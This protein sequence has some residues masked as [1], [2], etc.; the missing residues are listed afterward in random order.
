MLPSDAENA[1]WVGLASLLIP[2]TWVSFPSKSELAIRNEE[3]W[4]VQPPVNEN[5]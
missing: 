2:S 5:M 4:W 1:V 3:T